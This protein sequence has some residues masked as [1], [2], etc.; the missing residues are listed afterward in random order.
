VERAFP[1]VAGGTVS[2]TP[3]LDGRALESVAF[4]D[5]QSDWLFEF[6]FDDNGRWTGYRIGSDDPPPPMRPPD[7]L[8]VETWLQMRAP[9]I[10]ATGIAWLALVLPGV[11]LRHS[12]PGPHLVHG[13]LMAGVAILVIAEAHP[14]YPWFSFSNDRLMFGGVAVG[15]SALLLMATRRD[16]ARRLRVLAANQVCLT[17]GYDL[18]ATPERCPEC[19]TRAPLG[20]PVTT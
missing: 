4:V 18:R 8:A 11:A 5:P 13:S 17:C 1:A 7:H 19:G 14:G 6:K 12:A 9:L 16:A 10:P 15:V 20:E 2:Q 3:Q